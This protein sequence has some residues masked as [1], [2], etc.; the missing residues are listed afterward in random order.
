[1]S[2]TQGQGLAIGSSRSLG[3]ALC[4]AGVCLGLLQCTDGVDA[5]LTDREAIRAVEA[6]WNF[7]RPCIPLG[8]LHVV[9]HGPDLTGRR[10][11]QE[12][13][14]LIERFHRAGILVATVEKDLTTRF[15]GWSDWMSLTQSGVLKVVSVQVGPLA[16][17]MGQL[18]T[19]ND[20]WKGT[21]CFEYVLATYEVGKIV[22]NSAVDHPI[23][24]LRV[25]AGFYT[26]TTTPTERALAQAAAEGPVQPAV[27][28]ESKFRALLRYDPFE[29]RWKV[30]AADTAPRDGDFQ[31][32]RLLSALM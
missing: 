18:T 15:S 25:V 2:E 4:A 16:D 17:G 12:A 10:V 8:Q 32:S 29:A 9:R 20:R 3:V 13:W 31:T 14:E 21:E 26:T 22:Q 27:P 19:D 7:P 5:V 11:D 1:M 28:Q 6:D 24:R 23:D 30:N